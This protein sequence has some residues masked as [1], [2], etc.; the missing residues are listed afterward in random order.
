LIEIPINTCA[1]HEFYR[2][3]EVIAAGEYWAQ[4]AIKR[5]ING[6]A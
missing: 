3:E 2:A 5:F 6:N 1:A 4:A